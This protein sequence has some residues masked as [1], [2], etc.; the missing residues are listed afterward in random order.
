MGK[1]E[2]KP[3]DIAASIRD[4]NGSARLCR[5]AAADYLKHPA[6]DEFE[7]SINKMRHDHAMARA[8]AF[9]RVMAFLA[10]ALLNKNQ[11][12]EASHA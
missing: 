2:L 6:L 9:E 8:E 11:P 12:Q 7:R 1:V 5:I 3:G 4:L 10:E